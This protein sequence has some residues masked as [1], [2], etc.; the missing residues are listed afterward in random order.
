MR[1]SGEE[2]LLT[3]LHIRWSMF[4]VPQGLRDLNAEVIGPEYDRRRRYFLR[5]TERRKKSASPRPLLV[6][7]SIEHD[8][9]AAKANGLLREVNHHRS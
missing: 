9:D 6:R 2:T 4:H 3:R 8:I 1:K 5:G 7:Q